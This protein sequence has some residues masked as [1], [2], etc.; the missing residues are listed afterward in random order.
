MAPT[1][2]APS[3][4]KL[5]ET[6]RT[7]NFGC[8]LIDN[9]TGGPFGSGNAPDSVVTAKLIAPDKVGAGQKFQVQLRLEPAP[10]N[11]P[12]K[13]SV[14]QMT[15]TLA[16]KVNGGTPQKVTFTGTNT[17]EILP[18]STFSL[19]QAAGY[20]VA[21][22]TASAPVGE[23][24]VLDLDQIDLVGALAGQ[25]VDTRCNPKPAEGESA[26]AVASTTVIAG[27]VQVPVVTA[28]TTTTVP[29]SATFATC[30][31]ARAAGRGVIPRSSPAYSKSLDSDGDGLACEAN[32]G[33]ATGT[34]ASVAS[35]S[36]TRAATTTKV[37]GA[38][39]AFTGAASWAMAGVGLAVLLCGLA[40]M[41]AAALRNRLRP[42]RV[43]RRG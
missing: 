37:A 5:V 40:L 19:P 21:D 25:E 4:V 42:V 13:L 28:T 34:P 36:A 43:E 41:A 3:E 20:L 16:L 7:V 32:E 2:T 18:N 12:I 31:E 17:A 27:S 1:T 9:K 15:Y 24:V 23:R 11:G 14:G 10:K 39:L 30:A 33:A 35:A 29:K 6:S 22:V 38:A 8:R 26:T